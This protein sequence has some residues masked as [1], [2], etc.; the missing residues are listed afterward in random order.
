MYSKKRV[1]SSLL[2]TSLLSCPATDEGILKGQH[3][4]QQA[5][6][7]GD[8]TVRWPKLLRSTLALSSPQETGTSRTHSRPRDR[9]NHA[10]RVSSWNRLILYAVKGTNLLFVARR[11]S[12]LSRKRRRPPVFLPSATPLSSRGGGPLGRQPFTIRAPLRLR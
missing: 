3:F 11:R 12:I 9:P 4:A 7:D 8:H 6:Q 10:R 1:F 2:S 5:N